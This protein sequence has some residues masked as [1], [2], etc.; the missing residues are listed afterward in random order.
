MGRNSDIYQRNVFPAFSDEDE[1]HRLQTQVLEED[2]AGR[3]KARAEREQ[4]AQ[5]AR[6]N[7][8]SNAGGKGQDP[9]KNQQNNG[10]D[11]QKPRPQQQKPREQTAPWAGGRKDFAP[12]KAAAE[13]ES[14]RKPI[15]LQKRRKLQSPRKPTRNRQKPR[16][17]LQNLPRSRLNRLSPRQ[18]TAKE[19]KRNRH[20]KPLAKP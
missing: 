20:R 16:N 4:R 12:V 7:A 6:N 15:S 3:E 11:T 5:E 19:K 18:I 10:N 9:P 2:R 14:A 8:N 1:F 13:A 17:Q